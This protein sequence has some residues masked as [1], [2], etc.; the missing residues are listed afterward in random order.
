[1]PLDRNGLACDSN[2]TLEFFAGRLRVLS[3]RSNVTQREWLYT[4]S[5]LAHY[6][7]VSRV[8]QDD[9]PPCTDLSGIHDNFVMHILVGD[10]DT[11][12]L[13]RDPRFTEAAAAQT[14][15]LVGFF[16][17]QMEKLYNLP[18]YERIGKTFFGLSAQAH[19]ETGRKELFD[20]MAENFQ[21]WALICCELNRSL[22][23]EYYAL[24]N[25]Q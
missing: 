16:R 21:T 8:A 12:L 15:F 25:S 9:I 6:S 10:K 2:D 4:S 5:V 17:D 1:M 19:S 3:A 14:L 13:A 18:T 23:G 20:R 7:Q 24:R 22:R 11:S